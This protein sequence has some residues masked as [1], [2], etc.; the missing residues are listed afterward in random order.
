MEK[1]VVV[2]AIAWVPLTERDIVTVPVPVTWK[3]IRYQV[4]AL[5]V[6]LPVATLW[7]PVPPLS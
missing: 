2:G 5:M 4:P 3:R 7:N 6:K 1:V